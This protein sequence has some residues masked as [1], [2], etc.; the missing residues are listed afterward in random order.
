[1]TEVLPSVDDVFCT[2]EFGT[3][4]TEWQYARMTARERTNQL[5]AKITE[6]YESWELGQYAAD[7]EVEYALEMS[8]EDFKELF[9]YDDT[10]VRLATLRGS[11]ITDEGEAKES[12]LQ[13]AKEQGLGQFALY[14]LWLHTNDSGIAQ[15]TELKQKV[16]QTQADFDNFDHFIRTNNGRLLT[17]MNLAAY[18]GKIGSGGIELT[19]SHSVAIPV[20]GT[21]YAMSFMEQLDE[22]YESKSIP[23]E[24]SDIHSIFGSRAIKLFNNW[25]A[26]LRIDSTYDV[27]DTT[28]VAG[29]VVEG[30]PYITQG[31]DVDFY[32]MVFDKTRAVGRL[33]S[34]G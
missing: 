9:G 1:M 18:A 34:Q 26:L 19:N 24:A 17:L 5:T 28:L 14:G 4:L 15:K 25:E 12:L 20:E 10:A 7:V 3:A 32:R 16:A 29:D 22:V 27:S 23:L 11:A 2:P 13:A 33:A 8:L 31:R 30:P 6:K 21:S